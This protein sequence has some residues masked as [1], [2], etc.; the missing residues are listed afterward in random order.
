M[1]IIKEVKE[2]NFPE[3]T[4]VVVAS[5]ILGVLNIRESRDIDI[6]VLPE[7]LEELKASGDWREEVRYGKTFLS[8]EG[9]DIIPELSWEAYPTTTK[10]AIET[11]EYID[12]IPFFNL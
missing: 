9:I 1:D 2:L 8:R 3:G 4:Y 6:A 12:D 10:Q 7:L 5:G 11:A